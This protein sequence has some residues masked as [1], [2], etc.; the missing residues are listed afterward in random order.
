MNEPDYASFPIDQLAN[1]AHYRWTS[2]YSPWHLLSFCQLPPLQTLVHAHWLD[3]SI[4]SKC[5][6]HMLRINNCSLI[7]LGIIIA[8][9]ISS[10]IN[11]YHTYK[12]SAQIKPDP[13]FVPQASTIAEAT[14]I[15]QSATWL[16]RSLSISRHTP[17]N[18]CNLHPL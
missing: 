7:F 10:Q 6:T 5:L 16:K 1:F 2:P 11:K 9:I 14:S 4:N 13:I 18:P 3:L 8:H 12:V 17:N 15:R